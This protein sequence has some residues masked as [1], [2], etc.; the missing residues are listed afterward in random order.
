MRLPKLVETSHLGEKLLVLGHEAV[1]PVKLPLEGREVRER[2]RLQRRG[3]GDQR[4]A[5]APGTEFAE[6]RLAWQLLQRQP[7]ERPLGLF[8]GEVYRKI[9]VA[10]ENRRLFKR[11]PGAN[12]RSSAQMGA[13][14]ERGGK[15]EDG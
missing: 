8:T 3:S 11:C 13:A 5:D 15:Q 7:L 2:S 14:A 1:K 12:L 10:V 4:P 9:V 6:T